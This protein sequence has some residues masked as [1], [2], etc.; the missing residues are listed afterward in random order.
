LLTAAAAP[1]RD[2]ELAGEQSAVEAFEAGHLVPLAPPQKERKSMLGNFLTTKVLVS[3]LAALATG[4][5]ALAASNT[6]FAGSGP[7]HIATSTSQSASAAIGTASGAVK[8][9]SGV[10]H[11]AKTHLGGTGS[12][13]LPIALPHTAT[14]LCH[15][16]IS[17]TA[18][19][20]GGAVSQASALRVLSNTQVLKVLGGKEFA[21][22]VAVAQTASAVPDYC[23]L[24]L[25]LP[26]LP[27]PSEVTALPSVLLGQLLSASPVATV[28]QLLTSLPGAVLGRVLTNLPVPVL[29]AIL[30]QMNGS[31]LSA[32]LT[33]LP[34]RALSTVLT[35]LQ[36]SVL[37]TILHGLPAPIVS[38]LLHELPASV[39]SQL[40]KSVLSQLPSS[41]IK[42]LS[43]S[44]QG[45]LGL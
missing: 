34:T 27:Q 40:P 23:A 28:S 30:T 31:A 10:T 4:G 15:T 38:R 17:D 19:L 16:L 8:S 13:R 33:G 21:S 18:S 24:V 6:V 14:A 2:S 22:L 45:I 42:S 26:Q 20:A 36:P 25:H 35:E 37:S 5:A 32:V 41:V 29:S 7:V 44:I 12:V 9:V 3:S 1:A 43:H 39:L 11:G